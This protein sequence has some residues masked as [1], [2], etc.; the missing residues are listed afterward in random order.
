MEDGGEGG[1]YGTLLDPLLDHT[2]GVGL[3]ALAQGEGVEAAAHGRRLGQLDEG[4]RGV[5]TGGQHEDQG[6]PGRGVLHHLGYNA[7]EGL[8]AMKAA[9]MVGVL[10]A[11]V[12]W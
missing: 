12:E 8:V 9:G 2:P 10:V 3:L 6:V 11:V 4:P 5:N 1:G 7:M